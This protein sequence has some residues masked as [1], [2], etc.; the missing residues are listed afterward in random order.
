MTV[1]D[2]VATLRQ[3]WEYMLIHHAYFAADDPVRVFVEGLLAEAERLQHSVTQER[4]GRNYWRS[5]VADEQQR[6]DRLR[7][8]LESA[9]YSLGQLS[10]AP[11]MPGASWHEEARNASD[12]AR[13][14][15]LAETGADT[16]GQG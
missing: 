14:V 5:M 2:P 1:P 3:K 9:M 7:K 4:E 8:A 11:T 15:I 16:G 12:R 13:K 6:N 10:L